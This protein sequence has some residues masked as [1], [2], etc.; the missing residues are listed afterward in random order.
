MGFEPV[1]QPSK[2]KSVLEFADHIKDTLSKVCAAL[3]KSKDDITC[4]YNQHCRSA[5]IFT[6]SDKVFLD[7]FNI[8]TT[9][10]SKKLSHH[11]LGPFMFIQPVG[12]HAYHL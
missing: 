7:A 11:F 9:C 5:P 1:Q 10:P 12:L 6:A 8:C 3:A 4:Y 2:V